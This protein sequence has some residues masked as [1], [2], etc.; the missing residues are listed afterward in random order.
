MAVKRLAQLVGER[1]QTDLHP[2]V[3]SVQLFEQMSVLARRA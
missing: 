3:K 1:D 2:I